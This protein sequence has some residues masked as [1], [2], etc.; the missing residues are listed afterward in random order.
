MIIVDT[1]EKRWEHI[2]A[3]FDK[4][5]VEYEVR[6]LDTGDYQLADKPQL[7]IDRKRTLNELSHNLTN[8][9]D[10]SRFWKEVRRSREQ[11]TKLI[12]LC[13][14]GGKI[15][16]IDDVVNWSDKYSGVTGKHLRQELYRVHIAYNVE[17]LFT[18][19]RS[20]ARKIIEL[21]GGAE[22]ANV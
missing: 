21:L 5:G 10:H 14:H 16:S 17:F 12:V 15:K 22:D 4:H 3:Y 11:G 20:T 1:R 13:E 18:N 2:K 8:R 6:K 19:K 7:V 9:K